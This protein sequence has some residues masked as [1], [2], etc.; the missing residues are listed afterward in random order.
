[1]HDS[2]CVGPTEDCPLLVVAKCCPRSRWMEDAGWGILAL[3][4]DVALLRAMGAERDPRPA[5]SSRTA[6][7]TRSL[8]RAGSYRELC[9]AQSLKC[10]Y[11]AAVPL[12]VCLLWPVIAALSL[13][14]NLFFPPPCVCRADL[15][16]LHCI[17]PFIQLH[18]AR[19]VGVFSTGSQRG[20]D[21][22]S[23]PLST[24]ATRSWAGSSLA[25]T[26]RPPI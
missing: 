7:E 13:T 21:Q 17:Q 3:P 4:L 5:Q 11:P 10:L 20:L 22:A 6:T 8:A 18:A 25:H 12:A 24:V 16:A 9:A 19:S 2:T 26:A 15:P 23:S 14:G 1:M